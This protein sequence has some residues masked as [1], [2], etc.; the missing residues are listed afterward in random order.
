M[1][2]DYRD[3]D[4]LKSLTRITGTLVNETP[5]RIGVGRETPSIGASVD[6]AVFRVN[7]EPCIPGSSLKGLFRSFVEIL[8]I[9]RGLDVHPIFG[10]EAQK[11]IEEEAKSGEFCEVC[12]IFGNTELASHIRV[13]DSYPKG[14]AR[15]FIKAGV[16]INRELQGAQ[17]GMLYTEELVLPGT[18]WTFRAD[19]YNIDVFPESSDVRG[20]LLRELFGVLKNHGL[21]VGARRTVGYGL[22]KLKDAR[23]EVFTVENGRLI[24]KWEGELNV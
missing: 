23:A 7:G 21:Q 1:P 16:G 2:G 3:L 5:M 22:I 13:F 6:V 12:G 4:R 9:N 18:N 15:T 17:P 24:K 8:A 11:K 20:E 10:S 19:I 14:E